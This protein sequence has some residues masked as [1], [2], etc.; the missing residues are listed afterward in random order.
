MKFKRK[1]T[2]K[3]IQGSIQEMD[4]SS[5]TCRICHIKPVLDIQLINNGI[6]INKESELCK[7]CDKQKKDKGI[8]NA[9]MKFFDFKISKNTKPIKKKQYCKCGI[10]SIG[11]NAIKTVICPN[12]HLPIKPE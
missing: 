4:I 2:S 1:S 10:F 11:C 6:P 9:I 3:I 5:F 12:C 7:L 8:S